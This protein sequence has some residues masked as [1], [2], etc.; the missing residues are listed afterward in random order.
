[1]PFQGRSRFGRLPRFDLT[2]GEFPP[3]FPL[4]IPAL[5][6][7]DPVAFADDGGH[8]LLP[9]QDVGLEIDDRVEVFGIVA[10]VEIGAQEGIQAL[11]LQVAGALLRRAAI[12][13]FQ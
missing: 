4:A 8:D 12:E 2:A 7:E 1:M 11:L 6:S 3:V 13:A 9:G 10:V 5:G